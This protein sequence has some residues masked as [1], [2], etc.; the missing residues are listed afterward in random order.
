[1][2]M[3]SE[4]VQLYLNRR[5]RVDN[6][7]FRKI[8]KPFKDIFIQSLHAQRPSHKTVIQGIFSIHFFIVSDFFAP[9]LKLITIVGM[10]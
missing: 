2:H 5:S 9:L 7:C 1:M 4:G 8:Q 6:L 3:K 10:T